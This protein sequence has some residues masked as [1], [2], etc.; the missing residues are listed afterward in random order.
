MSSMSFLVTGCGRKLLNSDK[1]NSS[2]LQ[3]ESKD[4][5]S[6]SETINKTTQ[7]IDESMKKLDET[8]K[9]MDESSD[10]NDVDSLVSNFN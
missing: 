7:S 1:S 3:V 6:S 9:D 4:N 8:L 2:G 5:I 10:I